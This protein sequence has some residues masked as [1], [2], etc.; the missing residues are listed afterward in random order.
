M[1]IDA[2]HHAREL[3]TITMTV[4]SLLH[5]LHGYEHH[6]VAYRTLLNEIAIV[7]IP[8]VNIDGVSLISL[9]YDIYNEFSY[10]RKNRSIYN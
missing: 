10:V 4:Y 1:I 9:E 7:F 6:D 8:T 5:I 3:T 2:A